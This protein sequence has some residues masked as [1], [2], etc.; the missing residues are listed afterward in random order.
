MFMKFLRESITASFILAVLRIYLGYTWITAGYHKLTTG[1]D[2][3]GFLKGAI[4]NPVKATDGSMVFPTYVGFLK[5]FALPNANIFDVMIPI[6]E[7]LVGL[8]LILGCLTTAAAFFA[9]LMNFSYLMA[10]TISTNPLDILL[11]FFIITAG[12]NAGRFGLD[13]WI[14]PLIRRSTARERHI[15]RNNI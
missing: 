3:S 5:N 6:G 10:G 4:A 14:I 15:G 13:R 1:F 2:A 11:G 12:Y 8:G 9:L 7:F